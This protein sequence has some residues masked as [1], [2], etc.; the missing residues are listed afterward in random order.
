VGPG[1]LRDE[2]YRLERVH[3]SPWGLAVLVPR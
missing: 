2:P 3:E 1:Y